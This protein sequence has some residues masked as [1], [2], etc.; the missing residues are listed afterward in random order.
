MT[1]EAREVIGKARR[2]FGFSLSILILGFMAV[3]VAVVYRATR[4][5]KSAADLVALEQIILPADVEVRAIVPVNDILAIT[6]VENGRTVL[7]M[8]NGK[9]GE[10]IRDVPVL[11]EEE[12]AALAAQAE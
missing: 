12:A 9:T 6:L 8:L 4:D 11:N 3:V 10:L 1:D 5:Q 7:R 2:S